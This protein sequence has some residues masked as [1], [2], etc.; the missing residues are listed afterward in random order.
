LTWDRN[1]AEALRGRAEA[2]PAQP[3]LC[4]RL[5]ALLR[6]GKLPA[7]AVTAI[8]RELSAFIWAINREVMHTRRA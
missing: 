3:R 6:K 2:H 1:Q 7:I 5:R 8:A 4:D